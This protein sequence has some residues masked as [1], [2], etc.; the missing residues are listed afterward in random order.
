MIIATRLL[1]PNSLQKAFLS[2][3]ITG[4]DMC[5]V[6]TEAVHSVAL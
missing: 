4:V 3:Y 2:G 1:L 5:K 6:C